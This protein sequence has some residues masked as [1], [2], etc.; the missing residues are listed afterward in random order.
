MDT[1]IVIT[2][3]IP[4]DSDP[5]CQLRSAGWRVL[6]RR[7]ADPADE[8]AALPLDVVVVESTDGRPLRPL[9]DALLD[10]HG[11]EE[12]PVLAVVHAEELRELAGCSRLT[13][14]VLAP[15]RPGEL[16][17]RARRQLAVGPRDD[18]DRIRVAGLV[19]DLKGFE[20]SVDGAAVD[21]TYQEFR[22]LEFLASHPGHAFTRDQLLTRV[23]GYDYYGGSRT[24]DIHVRRIRAKLGSAYASCLQTI[25]HVGYKW[26]P[27][28]DQPGA[29]AA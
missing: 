19:I 12:L 6:P 22:L 16:A 5:V 13:D 21:L 15:L 29:A 11:F 28:A 1:A 10:A 27:G 9:L 3:L 23:W 8:I 17:A 2:P 20:V 26:V 25:R 14:F 18:D 4:R 7:P 24:V